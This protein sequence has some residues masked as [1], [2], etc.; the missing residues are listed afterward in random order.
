MPKNVT[1]I[2]KKMHLQQIRSTELILLGRI[3]FTHLTIPALKIAQF[4]YAVEERSKHNVK[5]IRN[6]IFVSLKF[7]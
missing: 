6:E 1:K 4:S 5:K 7:A 3:S 2:V